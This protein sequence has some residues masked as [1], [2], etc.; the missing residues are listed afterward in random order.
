MPTWI[1]SLLSFL[2]LA[3]SISGQ[4]A[5]K[6][7]LHL[8][9][10]TETNNRYGGALQ[11]NVGEVPQ[12]E[13]GRVLDDFQNSEGVS[14]LT[15][16]SQPVR[17]IIVVPKGAS[18]A[19]VREFVSQVS[20]EMHARYSQLKLD[21]Q[22]SL[23]D[24][25]GDA[26]ALDEAQDLL[27]ST[28]IQVRSPT[29][30]TVA[31]EKIIEQGIQ[32]GRRNNELLRRSWSL[33][34]WINSPIRAL[35]ESHPANSLIVA[36][37]VALTKFGTAGTIMVSKYGLSLSS[38]LLGIASGSVSAAFGYNAK[39]YSNFCTSHEIPFWRTNPL[40]GWYNRT[41]WFK[42]ATINSFR[43]I[44]LAYLFREL[45][46]L[47]GQTIKGVPVDSPNS[48]SFFAQGIGL[49]LPEVALDGLMD[50]GARGLELKKI[51]NHQTRS[52]I[53]WVVGIMDTM[54]HGFFRTG[55][56]E[57]AYVMMGISSAA[58]LTLYFAG[59]YASPKPHEFLVIHEEVSDTPRRANSVSSKLH[60]LIQQMRDIFLYAPNRVVDLLKAIRDRL[61][62]RYTKSDRDFLVWHHSTDEAWNLDL[63]EADL[64]R[65]R[66]D[67][68]LTRS[69]FEKT[70]NLKDS[71]QSL[72]DRLWN[73]REEL[74]EA[75]APSEVTA[76]GNRRFTRKLCSEVFKATAVSK[77]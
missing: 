41:G 73:L 69:Q 20:G 57:S 77:P 47:T 59:K 2:T 71:D 35:N 32:E 66:S 15:D 68:S 28:R 48:L 43:S 58:K 70:L 6:P 56:V 50:D 3:C 9:I 72:R 24:L 51:I 63:T 76:E 29:E 12:D 49:A 40:I 11:I 65:L 62:G 5:G 36:N 4:A 14:V 75:G 16:P 10:S 42:S 18:E 13:L 19:K 55:L 27:E 26:R 25:D 7:R 64:A 54:M 52:Y 22:K 74:R 33:R 60:P 1:F 61:S 67:R 37:V 44:G 31:L 45:A 38:A 46:V 21:V 53:Q 17:L 30:A 34:R 23:V 8:T 39:A